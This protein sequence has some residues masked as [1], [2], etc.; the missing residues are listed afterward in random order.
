MRKKENWREICFTCKE[1][2][3]GS[4]HGVCLLQNSCRKI[5]NQDQELKE[6][7]NWSKWKVETDR[8]EIKRWKRQKT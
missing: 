5:I 8:D 6:T 7:S 1:Y 2:K 3:P 4:V